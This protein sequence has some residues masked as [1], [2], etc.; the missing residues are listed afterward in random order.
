MK[1]KKSQITM[2]IF[3]ILIACALIALA[4]LVVPMGILFNSEMYAASEDIMLDANATIQTISDPNVKANLT[5]AFANSLAAAQN[6][7]EI[8]NQIFKY[9]WIVVLAISAIV[10]FLNLR[11]IVEFGPGFV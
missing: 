7:I 9:S 8:Q 6:N 4:A 3:F 5:S 10:L 2:Y 11:R 1:S